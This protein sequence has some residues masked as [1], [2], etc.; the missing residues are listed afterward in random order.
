MYDFRTA[1]IGQD[2]DGRPDLAKPSLVLTAGEPVR[3][4]AEYAA[5]WLV[6]RR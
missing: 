6:D 4:P 1:G 2:P 3:F 5:S